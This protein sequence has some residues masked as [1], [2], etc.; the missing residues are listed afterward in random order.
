MKKITIFLLVA[1]MFLTFTSCVDDADDMHGAVV[2]EKPVIYLYPG[3]NYPDDACD[4]QAD[5]KP[6]IYFDTDSELN[7]SVKLD[8][9]GTLTSTYPAYNDGWEVIVKTDGTIIDP[10]T[11]REYY[12][13]FWEGVSSVDYDFQK[14][15]VIKGEDT[16]KFL[17]ETLSKLGLSAREANEFII[18]WLPKMENNKYNLI[19]FQ[20]DVYTENAVLNI[21]P[22]PDSMLRVFMAWKAID[23]PIDIEPQELESFERNGFTVVEWGG[24]EVK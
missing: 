16:E 8:Y 22:S 19:S 1:A 7:V 23:E 18:Y 20:K 12:C 4:E 5:A 13:L 3:D 9:N 17:E 14:G 15:F 11:G 2:A 21:E 10:D 6:V 24:A